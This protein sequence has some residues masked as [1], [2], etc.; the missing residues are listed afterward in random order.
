MNKKKSSSLSIA[1]KLLMGIPLNKDEKQKLE[2]ASK[3]I[4]QS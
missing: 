1:D 3:R 2:Q 4:R